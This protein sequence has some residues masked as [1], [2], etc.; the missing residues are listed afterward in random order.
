MTHDRITSSFDAASTAAEVVEGIDLHGKRM[1]VTGG[2]SGIGIETARAL[3]GAGADVLIAVRNPEAGRGV[4]DDINTGFDSPRVT[5]SQLDLADLPSI[6]R[7]AAEWGRTPVHALIDNAGIMATP[8]TRTASGREVQFATNHL[9]H[10]TLAN[11]LHDALAAANGARIVSVSSRGHLRSPVVFDDIDF[12]EREYDPWLAYGQSKTANV[13]F[14]VDATRRWAD[15]GITANALHP[16]G[17]MTN[18][19]RY[20]PEDVLEGLRTDPTAVYKT[21]EQGAATSVFVATSPLLDGVGGRYFEDCNQAVPYEGG[22]ER[23]GV[24][25][26]ALDPE[27][28]QRLWDLSADAVSN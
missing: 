20:L 8:L 9:G 22:P 10:F 5:V 7:F 14:A 18:L 4:A 23:V 6:R 12:T 21:P 25:D 19:V 2:S 26:Y 11:A 28:A 24:A 3:A 17:I 16:G 13:L 15:D 27:A 1:I